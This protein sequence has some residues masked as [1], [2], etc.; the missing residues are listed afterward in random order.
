MRPGCC[1]GL[2]E[3]CKSQH[4]GALL[5][6]H[7]RAGHGGAGSKGAIPDAS[8]LSLGLVISIKTERILLNGVD[9]LLCVFIEAELLVIV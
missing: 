3:H 8:V 9:I 2:F 4:F 1:F 6:L 5:V 7:P